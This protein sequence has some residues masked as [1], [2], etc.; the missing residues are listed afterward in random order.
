MI[1]RHFL[2]FALLYLAIPAGF[3]SAVQNA[4]DTGLQLADGGLQG[5]C[6]GPDNGGE[7]FFPRECIDAS[8]DLRIFNDA[9]QS[10]GFGK[11]VL[12]RPFSL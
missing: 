10:G 5:N 9:I 11:T 8:H 4:S 3:V 7:V 12:I 6:P 1:R 2:F